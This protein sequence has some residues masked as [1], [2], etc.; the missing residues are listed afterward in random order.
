MFSGGVSPRETHRTIHD[1]LSNTLEA[2]ETLVEEGHV[3]EYAHNEIAKTLKGIRDADA[4]AVDKA[5]VKTLITMASETPAILDAVLETGML[6]ASDVS[7]PRFLYWLF[8]CKRDRGPTGFATFDP[9][10]CDELFDF[11]VRP[12]AAG[13]SHK[14]FE[15]QRNIVLSMMT[16]VPD[17]MTIVDDLI[18]YLN[19]V[20]ITPHMLVKTTQEGEDDDEYTQTNAWLVHVLEFAPGMKQWAVPDADVSE[21][22]ERMRS[23]ACDPP[24]AKPSE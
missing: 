5:V 18:K 16:A 11:Y 23:V 13:A 17:E 19:K 6:D 8:C 10:W 4:T 22:A 21:W 1:A 12:L 9:D 20:G 15:S 14:D 2:V 7:H 24:A 3:D